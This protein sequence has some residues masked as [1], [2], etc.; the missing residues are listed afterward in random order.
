MDEDQKERAQKTA[1]IHNAFERSD[2]PVLTVSEIAQS[3][4]LR[5]QEVQ[6]RL[7]YMEKNGMVLRK[8]VGDEDVWWPSTRVKLESDA[9]AL[10]LDPEYAEPLSVKQ[11]QEILCD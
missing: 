7:K 2:D 3:L 11:I 5:R 6:A 10:L 1:E 8:E 9:R 4:K